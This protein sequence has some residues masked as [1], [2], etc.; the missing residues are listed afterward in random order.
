MFTKQ[1]SHHGGPKSL[2]ILAYKLKKQM[3]KAHITNS[4]P[5]HARIITDKDQIAEE[6][7]SYYTV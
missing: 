1:E 7:A 2:K 5:E 3:K 6:F 4:K